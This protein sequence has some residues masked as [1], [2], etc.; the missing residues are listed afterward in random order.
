VSDPSCY[1]D[2]VRPGARVVHR[3][4]I[5]RTKEKQ[6]CAAEVKQSWYRKKGE[7]GN[8]DEDGVVRWSTIRA[9]GCGT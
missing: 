8:K 2:W 9:V 1:E 6:A 3:G 4:L 7:G 5:L